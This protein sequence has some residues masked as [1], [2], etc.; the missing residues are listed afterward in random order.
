[1]SSP[2]ALCGH[3]NKADG[4]LECMRITGCSLR[5]LRIARPSRA[6]CGR[7]SR[8]PLKLKLKCKCYMAQLAPPRHPLR[9]TQGPVLYLE[10]MWGGRLPHFPFFG[11]WTLLAGSALEDADSHHETIYI[12]REK[13]YA[14]FEVWRV[15]LTLAVNGAPCRTQTQVP[16]QPVG[17]LGQGAASHQYTW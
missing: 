16:G 7:E 9:H 8:R 17:K 10:T 5:P 3:P 6:T 1:M 15:L 12:L 11:R 13:K 2:L 14:V 4:G